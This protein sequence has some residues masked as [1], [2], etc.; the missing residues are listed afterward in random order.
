MKIVVILN[1]TAT[2]YVDLAVNYNLKTLR[3]HVL[4]D[5]IKMLFSNDGCAVSLLEVGAGS[6]DS[7]AHNQSRSQARS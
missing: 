3:Q 7:S 2:V 6:R 1:T 5:E 4:E